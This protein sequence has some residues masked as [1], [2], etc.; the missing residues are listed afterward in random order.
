MKHTST[1]SAGNKMTKDQKNVLISLL[2]H[3][4]EHFESSIFTFAGAFTASY[5]FSQDPHHWL[6]HYGAYIAISSGLFLAPFGAFIFSWIGDHFGRRPALIL[7]YLMSIVPSM[8]IPLI[9]SYAQIGIV[10]SL[11]LILV[12]IFQ[13]LGG[14]GAF[15]GRIVLV[16]EGSPEGRNLNMGI[17]MSL[18]FFGALLGTGLSYVFIT[19]KIVSWGWKIPYFLASALGIIVLLLRRHLTESSE[20]IE[21]KKNKDALPTTKPSIPLIQCLKKF[22]ISM[23]CVFCFGLCMLTPFYYSNIWIAKHIDA[24]SSAS[25]LYTTLAM[26]LCGTTLILFFWMITYVRPE[27]MLALAAVAI[28]LTG[29][30]LLVGLQSPFPGFHIINRLLVALAT[31]MVV[32]PI[33]LLSHQLFPVDFRYT[34]F[35]IPFFLGQAVGNGPTPFYAELIY[36]HTG[37]IHLTSGL[38]FG[39]ALILFVISFVVKSQ[40]KFINISVVDVEPKT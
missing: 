40:R 36:R 39:S 25:L 24:S 26:G 35:A 22:P 5:F 9:P 21:H 29:I 2:G 28:F 27:K 37:S 3:V 33:M 31:S 30:F 1:Q 11:L 10:A 6:G 20:W 12:R 13:G 32:P 34:G 8:L 19:Y 16:G 23:F 38:I 14:S 18:G 17:L 15:A 7:A 4:F